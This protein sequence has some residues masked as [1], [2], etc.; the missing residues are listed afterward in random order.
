MPSSVAIGLIVLGGVFLLVA[1]VGG[2]FSIFGAQISTKVTSGAMRFLA[3]ILGL[4]FVALAVG[5]LTLGDK[6][7][8]PSGKDTP[9]SADVTTSDQPKPAAGTAASTVSGS[10]NSAPDR[11]TGAVSDVV[12]PLVVPERETSSVPPAPDL[13]QR[14]GTVF[15]PPS[16]VRISPSLNAGILCSV[17]FKRTI[18]LLGNY[19]PW[20][21]TD[22]C[23]PIGYIHKSQVRF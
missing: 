14:T 23:G 17:Q 12:K 13:N 20:F 15:D 8:E 9:K 10:P 19:D 4:V 3:G 11:S 5:S 1:I 6:T 22:V 16:N 7:N 21:A 18:T 2:N